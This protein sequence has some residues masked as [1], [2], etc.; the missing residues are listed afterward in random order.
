MTRKLVYVVKL[1]IS[2]LVMVTHS[3]DGGFYLRLKPIVDYEINGCAGEAVDC[4]GKQPAHGWTE[5][6]KILACDIAIDELP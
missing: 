6:I 5:F 1:D 3:L 4:L 2:H